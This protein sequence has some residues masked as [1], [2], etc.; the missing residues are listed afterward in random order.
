M[1]L[2]IL[3]FIRLVPLGHTIDGADPCDLR[4]ILYTPASVPTH[5]SRCAEPAW[6]PIRHSIDRSLR[7]RHDRVFVKTTP[8]K[9]VSP[10]SSLQSP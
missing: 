1:N 3:S 4:A 5:I 8:N 7:P 9:S 10:V 6:T 2:T